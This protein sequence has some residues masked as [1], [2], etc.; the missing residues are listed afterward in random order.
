MQSLT[1]RAIETKTHPQTKMLF[2]FLFGSSRGATNRIKIISV[3]RKTSRNKNQLAEQLGIDYKVVERHLKTLEKNSL[4]TKV[5]GNYGATY[6]VSPL[7]E[8]SKTDFDEIV[9]K[10]EKLEKV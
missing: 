2:W 3:I 10:L 8:E 1:I 5:G 4:V 9:G 7:F 6:F